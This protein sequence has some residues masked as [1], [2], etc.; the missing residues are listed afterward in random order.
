M[1]DRRGVQFGADAHDKRLTLVAVVAEDADLDELVRQEVDVD[2]MQ[3]RGREPV[4][5]DD[6]ERVEVVGLCAK[7]AAF[8]RC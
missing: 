1:L 3:H 6:D 8:S 4:L 7:G 2:L 5:A